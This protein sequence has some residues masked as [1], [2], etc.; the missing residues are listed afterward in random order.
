[1]IET[2]RILMELENI[3]LIIKLILNFTKKKKKK[4]KIVLVIIKLYNK[5]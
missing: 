4:K 5:I 2:V 3:T 1:M